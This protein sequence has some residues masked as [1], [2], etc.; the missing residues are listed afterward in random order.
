MVALPP[1]TVCNDVTMII[2]RLRA[3]RNCVVDP[4]AF[5]RCISVDMSDLVMQVRRMR[6]NVPAFEAAFASQSRS[7]TVSTAPVGVRVSGAGH[8]QRVRRVEEHKEEEREVRYS[9]LDDEGRGK[10]RH[11]H[12][13]PYK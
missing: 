13:R 1:S 7:L 11:R 2:F 12:Y 3:H 6:A 9:I 10:H 4:L 8:V 5:C